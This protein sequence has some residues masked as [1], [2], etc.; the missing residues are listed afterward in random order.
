MSSRPDELSDPW[1]FV[2]WMLENEDKL[3]VR[4]E[5]VHPKKNNARL[6]T[7]LPIMQ[8]EPQAWIYWTKR[9]YYDSTTQIRT[10]DD[11]RAWEEANEVEPAQESPWR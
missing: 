11:W 6:M 9:F 5:V 7:L 1:A 8:L 2:Q 10:H 4:I 3:Y